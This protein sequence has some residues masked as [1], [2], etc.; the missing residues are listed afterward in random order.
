MYLYK[1]FKRKEESLNS[2]EIYAST[3]QSVE[4][5]ATTVLGVYTD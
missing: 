2:D 1:M 5:T 4:T 3:M